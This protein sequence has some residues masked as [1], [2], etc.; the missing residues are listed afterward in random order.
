MILP[1]FFFFPI[2]FNVPRCL[3]ECWKASP[4]SFRP[5]SRVSPIWV[6]CLFLLFDVSKKEKES[7]FLSC[8]SGNVGIASKEAID[9]VLWIERSR[10]IPG[11]ERITH[12]RVSPHSKWLLLYQVMI[13]S[14][15]LASCR[16]IYCAQSFVSR[17]ATA[18]FPFL[19]RLIINLDALSDFRRLPRT[20]SLH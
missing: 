15:L 8:P 2:F 10:R 6:L 9:Q 13:L 17:K 11:R 4:A 12:T 1:G 3:D 7:H 20:R 18:Q 16:Y 14:F 19:I 5:R